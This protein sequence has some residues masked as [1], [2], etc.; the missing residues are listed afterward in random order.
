MWAPVPRR[1]RSRRRS[2]RRSSR[3]DSWVLVG[4]DVETG[5]HTGPRPPQHNGVNI[6]SG[7]VADAAGNGDPFHLALAQPVWDNTDPDPTLYCHDTPPP[8]ASA[9]N[10]AAVHRPSSYGVSSST[11]T[12][13]THDTAILNGHR[14][15]VPI[16][17][18]A[19]AY[20]NSSELSVGNMHQHQQEFT[21]AH[22]G[23]ITVWADNA[24]IGGRLVGLASAAAAT[25]ATG[26]SSIAGGGDGA[27]GD[28][29]WVLPPMPESDDLL[30]GSGAWACDEGKGYHGGRLGWR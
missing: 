3:S 13:G 30:S 18:T 9:V 29:H 21:H 20:P 1:R 12:A 16:A 19:A 7:Q 4:T 28:L 17:A 14:R 23:S 10:P 26:G 22:S 25:A 6:P 27:A 15:P 2:S 11:E 8:S 5:S 24:G